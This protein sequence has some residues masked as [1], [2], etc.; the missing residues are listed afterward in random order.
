MVRKWFVKQLNPRHNNF[1]NM[2]MEMVNCW[3][4]IESIF[5]RILLKCYN[6]CGI[7]SILCLDF[8]KSPSPKIFLVLDRPIVL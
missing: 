8:H 4:K 2:E 6:Q 3:K 1:A 5:R 7:R